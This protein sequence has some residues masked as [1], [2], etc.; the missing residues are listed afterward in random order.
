MRYGLVG[1]GIALGMHLGVSPVV[2][3]ADL[4]T[5]QDRGH[6]VVAVKDTWRPLGFIDEKGELVGF[7]IDLARQLAA[8]LLGDP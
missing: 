6:L 1:F 4:D 8:D 3:S 7:E 2:L 5:I